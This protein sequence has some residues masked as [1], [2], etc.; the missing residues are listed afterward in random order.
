MTVFSTPERVVQ[1][2]V[3]SRSVVALAPEG[4]LESL[5]AIPYEVGVT[6]RVSASIRM[7]GRPGTHPAFWMRSVDEDRIGEIDVVE[8]WGHHRVCQIVPLAGDCLQERFGNRDFVHAILGE[9]NADDVTNSVR[10]K[11]A[12]AN[13]AFDASILSLASLGHAKMNR[14]LPVRSLSHQSSDQ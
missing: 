5:Q 7:P 6:Y 13:R 4:N 3:G 10:E 1:K 2:T 11:A 9:G 8:S 12:D 14:I